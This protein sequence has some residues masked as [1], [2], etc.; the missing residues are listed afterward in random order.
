[1]HINLSELKKL[2]RD[3]QQKKLNEIQEERI[4]LFHEYNHLQDIVDEYKEQ[5]YKVCT[6]IVKLNYIL[7]ELNI[8]K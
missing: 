8:I 3:K 5:M 1:M 4:R 6:E 2:E 7:K